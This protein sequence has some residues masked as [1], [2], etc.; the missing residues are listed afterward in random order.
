MNNTTNIYDIDNDLIRAAGDNH[1]L[2]IEEAQERIKHYIEKLKSLSIEDTDYKLKA[3]MYNQYIDNLA[4]YII[5]KRA[6]NGD[7][8]KSAESP[9][10]SEISTPITAIDEDGKPVEV[11]EE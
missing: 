10:K 7:F 1:E 9:T 2:T 5:R 11:V 8:F 6:L 4:N 3:N